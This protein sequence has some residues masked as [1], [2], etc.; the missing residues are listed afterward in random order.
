MGKGYQIHRFQVAVNCT[1]IRR[2]AADKNE[3]GEQI[4]Y[5]HGML[6]LPA[7]YTEKGKPTRL[8]IN[9]HGAGG[10][11]STDD[12]QV[13]QQVITRYL[14]AN[15]YAVMDVNGLPEEY[16]GEYGIDIRNNMGKGF[17]NS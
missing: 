10:T 7:G 6:A 9:C 14:L 2:D 8:V 13:E 12:S 17:A 16:A 3:A 4:C 5:D 11:V 15:G 1:D